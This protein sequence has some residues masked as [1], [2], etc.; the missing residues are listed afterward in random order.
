MCVKLSP[1]KL[2]P[3]SYPSHP[4]NTYTC[5]VA[6]TLSLVEPDKLG[7]KNVIDF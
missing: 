7:K 4:P 2:N 3:D 6:I 1:R 5:G